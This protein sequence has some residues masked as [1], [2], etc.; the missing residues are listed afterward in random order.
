MKEPKVVWHSL[1]HS[2]LVLLYVTLV[3]TVMR[4]ANQWFPHD[5]SWTPVAVLMLFVLSAA[6]TGTLVVGKPAL[7]YMEGKRKEALQFF[8]FTVMWLAILTFI[9]L[10]ILS[11]T[12][13]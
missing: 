8:G 7:M 5:N 3:G 10:L 12:S 11:T 6:I 4:H 13:R 9:S 2:V 1:G